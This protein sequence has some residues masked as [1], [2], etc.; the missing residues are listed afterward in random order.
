[1]SRTMGYI[2][3]AMV[4]IIWTLP[5]IWMIISGFR[6]PGEPFYEGI[7]PQNPT[8]VNFMKVITNKAT[9]RS[10]FNSF[11]VASSVAVFD[12]TVGSLAAYGF[13]RFNFAGKNMFSVL[14]LVIRLFPG[15]LLALALFQI[16]GLLG[17]YDT[18]FPLIL[19]NA[20]L[21]LPFTV[22]NLRTMF[23]ALPV[24]LEEAAWLDGASRVRAISKVLLPL[25]AP[26][27]AA[28][29]AFIFLLTWNEYLFAVSF[30][31]SPEK[32]LITTAIAA[33]IGQYNIDFTGLIATGMLAS[34]PLLIIF[35]VIQRYIV[36]GL[37][38]GAIK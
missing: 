34:V 36:S 20:L 29:G 19:A 27:L 17:V 16:A 10:F 28:T 12:L 35:L 1:M 37:G 30:I 32:Q 3:V 7:I 14:L 4:T 13:S 15:V 18:Y 33:N 24:E 21:L 5:I 9:L 22:W 6:D 11:I 8:L 25:M 38:M 2:F 26:G 23:D 31:R